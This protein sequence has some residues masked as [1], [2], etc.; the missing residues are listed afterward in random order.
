MKGWV[1]EI[2]HASGEDA[3]RQNWDAAF[4]K[5]AV[6]KKH[7][8]ERDMARVAGAF[9]I[10]ALLAWPAMVVIPCLGNI[11]RRLRDTI[12]YNAVTTVILGAYG[13]F[14]LGIGLLQ[15]GAAR[16]AVTWLTHPA[17]A[18]YPITYGRGIIMVWAAAAMSWIS[19]P[20]VLVVVGIAIITAWSMLECMLACCD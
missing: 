6:D 2:L 1:D 4:K 15:V 17:G 11:S 3:L 14:L 5:L 19:I 8:R 12:K 13:V 16:A 18:N 10:L 9:L 7:G 20:W